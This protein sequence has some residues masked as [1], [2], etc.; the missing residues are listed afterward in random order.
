MKEDGLKD[1]Y[2]MAA[3]MA[4]RK[5]NP[6]TKVVMQSKMGHSKGDHQTDSGRKTKRKTEQNCRVIT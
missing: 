4:R 2:V 3:K 5:L 6:M 1:V